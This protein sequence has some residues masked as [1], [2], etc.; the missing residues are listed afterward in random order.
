MTANCTRKKTKKVLALYKSIVYNN[1]CCDID[2]VE[3]EVAT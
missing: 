3:A 1:S 2:S